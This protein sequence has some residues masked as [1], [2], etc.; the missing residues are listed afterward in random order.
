MSRTF[1]QLTQDLARESGASGNAASISD[2]ANQTGVAGR[3]VEWI[4]Q[5]HREI[6]NHHNNW[7]WLR[8]TFSFDTVAGTDTYAYT[9]ATDTIA[10][11][12]I[13][14]FARWLPFDDGG[15]VNVKR[16]L[17][18]GGVGGE[19]WMTFLPW[20]YFRAIYRRGTQN[21]GPSIH[22]TVDPL[23]RIVLGPKPDDVYTVSGEY[24]KCSFDFSANGDVPEWPERFHD[25]VW[26][27][28]M[29]KYG[30]FYAAGEVFGR[31]QAEG[32]RLMRELELDQLPAIVLGAPLV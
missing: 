17:T 25:L 3:L 1:L 8:S 4:K 26:H 15:A 6:Q 14:R 20:S 16:Y 11:A 12:T 22:F 9:D 18:S 10:S 29:E 30:R 21:N 13:T 5:S 2:T 7:R 27:R 32:Y 31:S 19:L 28:A 23:N 24:M